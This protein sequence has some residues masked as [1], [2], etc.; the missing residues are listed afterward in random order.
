MTGKVEKRITK[1][2]VMNLLGPIRYDIEIVEKKDAVG[3]VN[4]MAWTVVG[5]ELLPIEVS[6]AHG[7]GHLSLTGQLGN[8]MQESA[9]TAFFYTRANAKKFG[10][11]EDFYKNLDVHIHAPNGAVPK[12]GPSA[13]VTICMA[14]ISA[15]VNKKVSHKIAMT[16][17]ITLRGNVLPVGGVKEKV[18]GAIRHGINTIFVPKENLGDIPKVKEKVKFIGVSHV[19]EI[20]SRTLF[21]K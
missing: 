19:S 18:L 17:E 5:G 13:G 10:I 16:G 8:V 21:Q 11:D 6:V 14:L 7:T 15:L 20:L 1:S 12:D 2:V 4:G 3:V 9:Q